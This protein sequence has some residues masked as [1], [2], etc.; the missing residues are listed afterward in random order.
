MEGTLDIQRDHQW[1]IHSAMA[2]LAPGG[3]LLF[4]TNFRRFKLDP[5]LAEGFKVADI[6]KQTIP[7]DY[8]R[9]PRIH[10]CFRI[11]AQGAEAAA[12]S[13]CAGTHGC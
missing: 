12:P 6:T 3:I 9:N 1:L 8:A 4:S 13:G 2:L 10:T 7:A 5:A 11:E